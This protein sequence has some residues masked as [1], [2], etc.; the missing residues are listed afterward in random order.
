MKNPTTRP[1]LVQAIEAHADLRGVFEKL[2]K[3][4]RCGEGARESD[5]DWDNHRGTCRGTALVERVFL[6]AR[7][8]KFT[9]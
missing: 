7:L 8:V 9:Q 4:Q 1:S 3:S 2:A 6:G 5:G